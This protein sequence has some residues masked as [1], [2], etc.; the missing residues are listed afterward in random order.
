MNNPESPATER[1]VGVFATIGSVLA[2]M[3]GVQS[4]RV[5][6]RDFTRGNPLLFICVAIAMTAVFVLTLIF[7]VRA[8][9][10]HAAA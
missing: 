3:F 5:R 6:R 10:A 4:S 1:P 8:I 9:V 2:A 7:V